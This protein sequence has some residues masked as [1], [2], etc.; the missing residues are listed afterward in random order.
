MPPITQGTIDLSLPSDSEL[1]ARARA[2]GEADPLY[3]HER[4]STGRPGDIVAVAR[5]LSTA[6]GELDDAWNL[7]M[8]SQQQIGSSF[9][10]DG[11]A[12]F[13]HATHVGGLP[14]GFRDAGAQLADVS[15]RL[16]TIAH[17][18]TTRTEASAARV[19]GLAGQLQQMRDGWARQVAE[20][21]AGGLIPIERVAELQAR[22]EQ[23]VTAMVDAIAE[24]G[25]AIRAGIEQYEQTLHG[26]IT[27]LADQGHVPPEEM[28]ALAAQV[29]DESLHDRLLREYQVT[30]D[31]D[32]MIEWQPEG[33]A[34]WLTGLFGV[35]PMKMTAGEGRHLDDIGPLGAR[36]AYGIYKT[37]L[38][39]AQQ[40]FDGAG[41]TDGH[42]DAFR[43]AYWNAMLAHRFGEEWTTSYT[44]AH[45][46]VPENDPR[47]HASAEAMD[48][49][50]NEVGRQIA[51]DN[52][53]AGPEEL[54]QLVGQAV[55]DGRMVVVGPDGQLEHSNEVDLGGTGLAQDPPGRGGR[56]PNE[57]VGGNWAGGYN[58]GG[59]G[60]TY[61][62]V[63][64]Y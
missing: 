59:D 13:D 40:V 29:P 64:N 8:R 44:S 12:V 34:G 33:P 10:N 37:A 42:S 58:P 31:P 32:G 55:L 53:D 49:Y 61:G 54:K 52:P 39:D 35:D 3:E 28:Q 1:R 18:L 17:E 43:H 60:E 7:S 45:E 14:P 2:S 62:T 56:E 36:D 25:A 48:L 27:L 16:T 5:T 38:N 4:L 41:V 63:D 26:G 6:G 21:T 47:S 46:R 57:D 11:A 51:R 23:T 50:N 30:P 19:N 24:A 15:R 22:R 20:S 9:T